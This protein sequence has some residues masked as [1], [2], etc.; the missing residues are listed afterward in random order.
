MNLVKQII[1]ANT[2]NFGEFSYY[3]LI[4]E[5][6]E[7]NLEPNPDISI[8]SCKA[9]IEG[10]SKTILITLDNALNETDIKDYNLPKLFNDT[11]SKIS[12]HDKDFEIAFIS[13]FRHSVKLIGEIRTKR[14]DIAHGKPAPK[15]IS[16]SIE[17]ASFIEQLTSSIIVYMLEH[18]FALNVLRIEAIKY[19]VNS[20]FNLM[21]D[22]SVPLVGYILYSRALYDQDYSSY[23]EQLKEFDSD[24]VDIDTKDGEN[25]IVDV[26]T[27]EDENTIVDVITV[28]DED[29]FPAIEL[30]ISGEIKESYKTLLTKENS[31][32]A[33]YHLC[34]EENLYINEV[35]KVIELYLFDRRIPLSNDITKVLKIKPKLLER[36]EHAERI[37]KSILKYANEYLVEE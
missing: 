3:E 31:I 9:L 20:S 28:E 35:L 32:S 16:S 10:V 14:G 24:E 15:A 33:L 29:K 25:T 11:I 6:I 18:F 21:L 30:N 22:D 19:E 27:V 34:E 4:I 13:S 23:L 8:E 36:R 2:K 1:S 37:T 17:F 12:E 26:I 7:K 5:K